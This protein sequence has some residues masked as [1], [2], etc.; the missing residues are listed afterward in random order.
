MKR[1]SKCKV[2]KAKIDFNK[3]KSNKDGH[4]NCCRE[5][6]IKAHVQYYAKNKQKAK[7]YYLQTRE[8]RLQYQKEYWDKNPSIRSKVRNDYRVAKIS[9]TIKS[10]TKQDHSDMAFIY[11]IAKWMTDVFEE[12]FHVD[13]IIPL[14]GE[15]V[16]GLHVPWNLQ[17]LTA[18][19]NIS[20][21]NKFE[22]I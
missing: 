5:C 18:R 22:T 16:C 21:S 12:S 10:L 20:K 17:I 15:N 13:H 6:S 9:A 14:Q 2:T 11:E 7:D 3:C 4:N 1:C 8:D 19:D